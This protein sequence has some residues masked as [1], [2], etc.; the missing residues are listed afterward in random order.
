MDDVKTEE[1]KAPQAAS[2][3]PDGTIPQTGVPIEVFT[4]KLAIP[5]P[6]A[7]EE[8]RAALEAHEVDLIVRDKATS[9]WVYVRTRVFVDLKAKESANAPATTEAKEPDSGLGETGI[10]GP[11]GQPVRPDPPDGADSV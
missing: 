9:Q 2:G 11:D 4:Q 7:G 10:L 5:S 3:T 8:I 6:Q 1:T